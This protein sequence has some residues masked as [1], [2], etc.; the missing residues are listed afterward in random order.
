L[1]DRLLLNAMALQHKARSD[2][3]RRLPQEVYRPKRLYERFDYVKSNGEPIVLPC[4]PTYCR[5]PPMKLFDLSEIFGPENLIFPGNIDAFV[6]VDLDLSPRTSRGLYNAFARKYA[7]NH[8][9]CTACFIWSCPGCGTAFS[10]VKRFQGK[11]YLQLFTNLFAEALEYHRRN[12]EYPTEL[13]YD[14]QNLDFSF[15]RPVKFREDGRRRQRNDL[16][17]DNDEENELSGMSYLYDD[18]MTTR[19]SSDSDSS[20]SSDD[21]LEHE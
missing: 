11:P 9:I 15:T 12:R 8:Q 3:G 16:M 1:V 7:K 17:L 2:G 21:D 6:G 19:L 4:R 20:P 5:C 10:D 18:A 13:Y 14:Y